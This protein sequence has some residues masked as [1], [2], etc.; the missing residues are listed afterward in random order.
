MNTIRN[1]LRAATAGIV[2]TA[3]V[4]MAAVA[5]TGAGRRF[6][7]RGRGPLQGDRPRRRRRAAKWTSRSTT[8]RIC[9]RNRAANIDIEVVA[10]NAGLG[11]LKADSPVGIASR[12]R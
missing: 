10:I 5:G 9:R 1:W 12:T 8:S 6:T 3:A 4:A 11:M 7:G 2:L